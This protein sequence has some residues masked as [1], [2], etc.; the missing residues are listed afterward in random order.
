MLAINFVITEVGSGLE[1]SET[2]LE[3]GYMLR[4]VTTMVISVIVSVF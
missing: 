1:L 4:V 2:K 3:D